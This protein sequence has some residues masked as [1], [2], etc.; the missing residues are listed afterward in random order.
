MTTFLKVVAAVGVITIA[1]AANSTAQVPFCVFFDS[2]TTF[3]GNPVPVG[4]II[5]AFDQTGVSCGK[6]TVLYPGYFGYMPVLGD[7]PS[8]PAFD[9]GA[10]D[11]ET[12]I[13]K[14]NGRFAAGGIGSPIWKDQ[15][16]KRIQLTSSSTTIAITGV[17]YP[18]DTIVGFNTTVRIQVGVRNDGD[19]L[20]Y[21]GVNAVSSKG[22]NI[23]PQP[24]F[25]YADPGDTA[26]I[27]FD[28][29]IPTFP[30]N[31]TVSSISYSVFTYLDTTK[32]VDSS[33][34]MITTIAVDVGDD[35]DDL[36]P[37]GFVLEQNYPNPFN[38]TTNI[39]FTLPVRS[40]VRIQVFDILGRE[41][42]SVDLGSRSAGQHIYEFNGSN[43]ASGVYFYRLVTEEFIETKKMMLVK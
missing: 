38:P 15:E 13:F 10:V 21:Y 8:T 40:N 32:H 26:F 31:D 11:G 33:M 18:E 43:R 2:T 20:D 28:V 7:D 42:E 24:D 5:E 19:G 23:T 3:D 9:E 17:D 39:A 36:L 35:F 34:S 12:I 29:Q 27:Y 4:S 25:V 1:A 41:I 16:V 37:S 14:I 22:W 6:D 30:G